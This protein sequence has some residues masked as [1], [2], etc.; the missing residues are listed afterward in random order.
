MI[1]YFELLEIEMFDHLTECKQTTYVLWIVYTSNHL[2][3]KKKW[4]QIHLKMISTK[5]V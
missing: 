3:V 1:S 2:T 4:T 5:C